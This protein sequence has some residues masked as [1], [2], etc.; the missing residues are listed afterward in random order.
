MGQHHLSWRFKQAVCGAAMHDV[1]LS[2][3]QLCAWL[4]LMGMHGVFALTNLVARCKETFG[5]NLGLS[6]PYITLGPTQSGS[7][8]RRTSRA[9]IYSPHTLF[10]RGS[11][12]EGQYAKPP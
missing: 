12:A 10:S 11:F 4:M 5:D 1:L 8:S 3:H 9:S 2:F 6:V 7:L